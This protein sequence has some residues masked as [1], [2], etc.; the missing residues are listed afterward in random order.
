VETPEVPDA[1]VLLLVDDDQAT[2]Q[3]QTLTL[4]KF[5]HQVVA[6]SDGESAI[7]ALKRNTDIGLVVLDIEL[8]AG[9]DGPS[10]ARALLA[11]RAL[12][13]VFLTVH[14]EETV[15]EKVSDVCRYG[16][17][18]KDSGPWVL[19]STIKMAYELF[20][21]QQRAVRGEMC[22]K[23][24]LD[25]SPDMVFL[26]DVS[27]R[28]THVNQAMATFFNLKPEQIIGH[29]DDELGL[30]I[31]RPQMVVAD[32]NALEGKTS[33]LESER[34][35]AKGLSTFETIRVPVRNPDGTVFGICGF[36][37]D[38]SA[39]KKMALE[40]QEAQAQAQA[41]SAA[42]SL[43]LANM[44][45]E[46]RTPLNGIMGMASLLAEG[47]LG[48]LER[49]Y[50]TML[51]TSS[52]N[53]YGLIKDLL[54]FN[55]IENGKFTLEPEAFDLM[56]LINAVTEA[57]RERIESKDV[58]FKLDITPMPGFIVADRTRVAQILTNLLSNAWKFTDSGSVSLTVRCQDHKLCI[59]VADTGCGIP[60]T[61]HN[62]VF[63]PFRQLEELYTKRHQGMGLG[64]SIVRQ[65]VDLMSGTITLESEPD[66][67]SVFTIQLPVSFPHEAVVQKKPHETVSYGI[68]HQKTV[69]IV[70]DEAINRLYLSNLLKRRGWKILEADNGKYALSLARTEKIDMVIM[71]LGLPDMSGIDVMLNIR[72]LPGQVG[73]VRILALTA[74]AY[75]EDRE[76]CLR[77]GANAFLTK[78]FDDAQLGNALEQALIPS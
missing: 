38:I 44:S 32:Q 9:L 5:G 71:D 62:Q 78:P 77:A 3:M 46:L 43:F 75:P 15:V 68:Q 1:R 55:R 20:D 27:C 18:T 45:H 35:S 61:K 13:I 22:V 63:D 21:A 29:N 37:R 67:G 57:F 52:Q 6:V 48:P 66:K 36:S 33:T 16:Y 8:G 24:I 25:S 69:L 31:G 12:P 73:E 58:L 34:M 19:N 47:E 41:A 54:D 53:L 56:A 50:L 26:K 42:K 28:F 76:R 70:E 64:L 51:M 72:E 40:L 2:L 11:I 17:V 7:D 59:R 65:L 4:R 23:A 10:T 49:D 60:F 39:H 14:D 30:N 74:H